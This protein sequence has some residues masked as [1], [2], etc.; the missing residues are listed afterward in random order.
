MNH[1][2]R[3]F[4]KISTALV[5]DASVRLGIPART[6]PQEIRPLIEATS[7]AG[8]V[9]PA[10]HFGSVDVFLEAIDNSQ[11]G[12]VLVIDNGG[13]TDQAC[14]GDLVTLEAKV[15]GLSGIAVWGCHRDT[16]ELKQIG[17]PVFSLGPAPSAPTKVLARSKGVLQSV[18]FGDFRVSADDILFGDD[19]GLLFL[20]EKRADAVIE[21][22]QSIA[23]TEHGQALLLRRGRT[24]RSQL[25]FNDYLTKAS[26]DSSYTFRKH[27]R[28]IGGAVEE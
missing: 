5:F 28:E 18:R 2:P 3:P 26:K 16:R 19:D 10:K 1:D 6:A 27:L 13:R 15:S 23:K 14:I 8:R 4:A 20:P 24:L 17:F 22:A 7:I 12:D 21:K 9:L 11:K 25:Q